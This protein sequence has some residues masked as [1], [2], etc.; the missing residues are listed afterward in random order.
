MKGRFSQSHKR[1]ES[2]TLSAVCVYLWSLDTLE[3]ARLRHF[4]MRLRIPAA[5]QARTTRASPRGRG[6][7][8]PALCLRLA[9]S[10]LVAMS[11]LAIGAT[12]LNR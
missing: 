1:A 7:R 10:L 12:Y 8:A 5:R 11:A 2:D 9:S 4:G 6:P 3:T